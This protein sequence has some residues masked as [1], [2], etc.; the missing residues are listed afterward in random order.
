MELGHLSQF[1]VDGFVKCAM[2]DFLLRC[3]STHTFRY[4]SQLRLA[5]E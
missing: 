4:I 2:L 5:V 1:S 3:S